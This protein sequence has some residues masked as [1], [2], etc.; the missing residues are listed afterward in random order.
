MS[1]EPLRQA[2]GEVFGTEPRDFGSPS[3]GLLGVSD[4]N[5]G[6]Q[7]NAWMQLKD[8]ARFV[9][10]NL[11]GMKYGGWPVARLILREL[12]DPTLIEVRDG[13]A[14]TDPIV[15]RWRRDCWQGAGA[16]LPIVEAFFAPTPLPLSRLTVKGWE[17]ALV[18]ALFCLDRS[19]GFRR[20]AVQ[21]V[22]LA[23]SGERIERE[24]SPH[25][26]FY[27]PAPADDP[28]DWR[29]LLEHA[30]DR[31]EP[32]YQWTVQRAS[33]AGTIELPLGLLANKQVDAV[34]HT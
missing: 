11:E 31:M 30:R 12:A 2:F 20:R 32:L 5:E 28:G 3:R 25:L 6:V 26:D 4:G 8:G 24:V 27:F 22:T 10:V 16:R 7:W 1:R 15:V 21:P 19:R 33:Q 14:D 9:G 13:I 34:C 29:R 18:E 23:G 17:A